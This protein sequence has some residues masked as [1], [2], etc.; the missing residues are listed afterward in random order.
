MARSGSFD[1]DWK[2]KFSGICASIQ[3]EGSDGG[4][5]LTDQ[6]T[7]HHEVCQQIDLQDNSVEHNDS[8]VDDNVIHARRVQQ[9]NLEA[10]NNDNNNLVS[11]SVSALALAALPSANLDNG[12]ASRANLASALAALP[13][14]V[15]AAATGSATTRPGH[16]DSDSDSRVRYHSTRERAAQDRAPNPYRFLLQ[17]ARCPD[18][19]RVRRTHGAAASG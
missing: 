19:L 6:S 12:R 1:P 2:N 8:N 18:R 15:A 9:I 4:I 13:S 11:E 7:V 16:S 14:A 10:T 3:C 17:R 5:A